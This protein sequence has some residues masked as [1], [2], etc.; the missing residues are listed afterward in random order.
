MIR[1]LPNL[2]RFGFGSLALAASLFSQERFRKTPPVPEPLDVVRLPAIESVE[3]SN[4]LRLAVVTLDRGPFINLDL[5]VGAGEVNS[6]KELPGLAG[7][8]AEI[9]ARGTLNLS[10]EEIEERIEACGGMMTIT[11]SLDSARFSFRFLDVYLDQALEL[12]SQMVLQPAFSTKEIT[13]LKRIRYYDILGKQRNP[14]F[15]GRRQLLRLLFGDHPYQNACHNEDVIRNIDRKNILDFYEKYYRPNNARLLLVGSLSLPVATRRVSHYFNTWRRQ[16][17]DRPVIPELEP[18]HERRV[19]FVDLPQAREATLV[20]GNLIFPV[21]DPDYFPFLVLNQVLGGTPYSRL[22]MNLRESR[23]I[24]YYAFSRTEFHR[25]G[26]VFMVEARVIP[27]ACYDAIQEILR[28]LDRITREK[29][30]TFE[31]EQAKS[32]LI[33]NFPLQM[34]REAELAARLMEIVTFGLGSAHW[35]RYYDSL[36]LVD[37][38]QVHA[39]AQRYLKGSPIVVIVGDRGRVV[40]FLDRFEKVEVYDTRGTLQ[41]TLTKGVEE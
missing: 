2:L 15:V 3:L 35:D 11:T 23:G 38:K 21:G 33:G 37:E 6:P 5:V 18:N 26:G 27:S 24:A 41:Y 17:I 1:R 7:F 28:E 22:F 30:P 4:G 29:I 10:V 31:I 25:Y 34:E 32:Q 36:M 20:V 40:E 9:M 14:D 19:C 39:V 12:L 16:D 13:A 8:T